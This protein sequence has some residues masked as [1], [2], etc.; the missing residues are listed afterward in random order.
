VQSR[1]SEQE[2]GA[3]LDGLS[4]LAEHGSRLGLD[5]VSRHAV[6][7]PAILPFLEW[8]ECNGIGWKF[9]TDDPG[10]SLA[11]HGW[12][13]TVFDFDTIARRFG[14]W[15]PPG[16]SEEVAARAAAASRSFFISARL[17]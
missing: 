16:V 6:E 11:D 14:R 12:A 10:R 8:L 3:L 1:P 9:G 4:A 17:P 7:N 13:A 2:N 5:M 15:R